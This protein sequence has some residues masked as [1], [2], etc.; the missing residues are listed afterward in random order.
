MHVLSLCDRTGVMVQPWI[1]A[2]HHATIVDLQHP[3]GETTEGRLTRVGA[4]LFQWTTRRR[5]DVVFAFPDCTEFAVSGARWWEAKG[6]T[7][8]LWAMELVNRCRAIAER[9]PVW[10]IENPVGRLSTWWR[11]PDHIFDPCDYGGYLSPP[12]DAYTKRTCLWTSPAF[13][14][15]PRSAWSR[16]TGA[17][18]TLLRRGRSARTSAAPRRKAS[19]AP[20]TRPT[21]SATRLTPSA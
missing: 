18:C 9:S 11:K 2:G 13:V 1:E 7:P 15:P 16:R 5:F 17:G 6:P 12:G 8:F 21:T 14:M 4:D 10:M 3:V 19:R 20:S